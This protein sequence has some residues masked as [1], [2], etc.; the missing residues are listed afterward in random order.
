MVK[1][2]NGRLRG[3]YRILTD[4]L[5]SVQALAAALLTLDGLQGDRHAGATR[6]LKRKS[7]LYP[8]GAEVRNTRQLSV[9]SVEELAEIAASMGLDQ[10]VPDDM[11]PNLLIEGIPALT[12]LP[13]GTRLV[14]ESGAGLVVDGYNPPCT[15]AGNRIA[16][17]HPERSNLA[18]L[19]VKAALHR[20]GL[21]AW[22]ENPGSIRVGEQ[23]TALLPSQPAYPGIDLNSRS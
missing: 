17:R 10:I 12:L 5:G 21:V 7:G 4:E 16:A 13:P 23:V 3:I 6:R 19:F 2:L 8:A 14:F 15:S 18:N 11:T 9:L 1:E 20:R 22:V